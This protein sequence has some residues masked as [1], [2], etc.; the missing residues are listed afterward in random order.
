MAC[1]KTAFSFLGELC[2]LGPTFEEWDSL[3]LLESSKLGNVK[4]LNCWKAQYPCLQQTNWLV[5]IP[6]GLHWNFSGDPY[7]WTNL[8]ILR[9]SSLRRGGNRKNNRQTCQSGLSEPTMRWS[10]SEGLSWKQTKQSATHSH[11]GP[12]LFP[13]DFPNSLG[14]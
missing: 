2:L 11:P 8:E 3:K 12:F 5:I 4:F 1:F 9:S 10:L 13:S 14:F 7:I 6:S